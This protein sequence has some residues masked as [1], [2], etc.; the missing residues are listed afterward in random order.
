MLIPPL[1]EDTLSRLAGTSTDRGDMGVATIVVLTKKQVHLPVH[2][3]QEG[4]NHVSPE[5]AQLN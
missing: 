3:M 5:N 2:S 1:V 4:H